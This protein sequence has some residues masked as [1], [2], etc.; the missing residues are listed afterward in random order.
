M[1]V[2]NPEIA[3]LALRAVLGIEFVVHGFPKLKNLK[4]TAGFLASSGFKPGIFW[5]FI[6]GTTEFVGGLALLAGFA[7]RIAAGLLIIAMSVATLLKIFKWKVPFSKGNEAGWEWDFI[8]LG[9]LI[10][11]FLLGSG[12]YSVDQMMGWILG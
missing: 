12:S 3:S 7:S 5:A 1:P 4:A 6:L 11:L 9:G 8:I 10:A 2:F